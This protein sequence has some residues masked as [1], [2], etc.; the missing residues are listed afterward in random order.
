[1]GPL[2]AAGARARGVHRT[3]SSTCLSPDGDA[4]TSEEHRTED[5]PQRPRGFSWELLRHP[6][7]KVGRRCW[8]SRRRAPSSPPRSAVTQPRWP[9]SAEL[10]RRRR[11]DA[12]LPPARP[13]LSPDPLPLIQRGRPRRAPSGWSLCAPDFP[14]LCARSCPLRT[15]R[16]RGLGRTAPPH[17]HR[18]PSTHPRRRRKCL[19]TGTSLTSQ[20]FDVKSRVP[21]RELWGGKRPG[22]AGEE[23]QWCPQLR[24]MEPPRPGSAPAP[25]L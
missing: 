21:V 6:P 1:M 8:R 4:A 2:A 5:G 24:E 10:G 12:H 11:T 15:R 19:S 20:G 16:G 22:N 14:P 9:G 7:R 23:E 18:P 3:L 13:Q 25:W 17:P